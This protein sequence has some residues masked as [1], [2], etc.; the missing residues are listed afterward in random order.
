MEVPVP[1]IS[2]YWHKR[3]DDSPAHRWLRDQVMVTTQ[4]FRQTRI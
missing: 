4:V 3:H 2:M 1:E